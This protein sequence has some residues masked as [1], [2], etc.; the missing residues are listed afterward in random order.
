MTGSSLRERRS[1]ESVGQLLMKGSSFREQIN[2]TYDGQ[3]LSWTD[4]SY[5]KGTDEL[6]MKGSSFQEQMS[7]TWRVVLFGNRWVI[8]MTGISLSEQMSYNW[9]VGPFRN[10]RVLNMTGSSFHRWVTHDGQSLS[11][12]WG[13]VNGPGLGH[14]VLDRFACLNLHDYGLGYNMVCYGPGFRSGTDHRR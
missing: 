1:Y 6:L 4:E 10:W 11:G 13:D 7:Y 3:F 12:T 5:R 14:L 9:K 2:Y 8:N